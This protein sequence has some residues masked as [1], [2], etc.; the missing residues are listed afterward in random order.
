MCSALLNAAHFEAQRVR[1]S[2]Y[3]SFYKDETPTAPPCVHQYLY[4][5][6]YAHTG[7]RLIRVLKLMGGREEKRGLLN[8]C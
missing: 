5:I 8:S 4:H 3:I 2:F 7:A 6:L 1:L